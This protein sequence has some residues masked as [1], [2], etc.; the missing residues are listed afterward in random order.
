VRLFFLVSPQN[1]A[2]TKAF[3]VNFNEGNIGLKG[4]VWR[5]GNTESR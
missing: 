2:Y 3:C 4:D 5:A 1:Y